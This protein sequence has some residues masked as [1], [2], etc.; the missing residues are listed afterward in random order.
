M[1]NKI[2]PLKSRAKTAKMILLWFISIGVLNKSYRGRSLAVIF[3][4]FLGNTILASSIVALYS[5]FKIS[6]SPSL[7]LWLAKKFLIS[8]FF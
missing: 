3:F 8:Q 5:S 2:E 7:F 1:I 6:T 4:Q